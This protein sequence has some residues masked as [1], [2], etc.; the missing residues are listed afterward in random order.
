MVQETDIKEMDIKEYD[1]WLQ[2][3]GPSALVIR[4]SLMPV[5]GK[6]SVLFPPTFAASKEK[7]FKG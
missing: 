3:T 1:E 6:D 4:E 7:T 5:E 2:E